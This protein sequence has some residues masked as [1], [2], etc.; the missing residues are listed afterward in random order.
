MDH[1]VTIK[2]DHLSGLEYLQQLI[3]GEL[4]LP[5]MCAT[6]PMTFEE[7]EL[8]FVRMTATAGVPHMNTI[9]GIHG[10]FAATVIDSVTGCA[11]H[12]LMEPG[13]GYTT[14][15][16]ELKMLRPPPLDEQMLVEG[17]VVN[18][19]RRLAVA[20]VDFE[21]FSSVFSCPSFSWA[22]SSCRCKPA[23]CCSA[24]FSRSRTPSPSC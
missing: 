6:I 19:S 15:S 1:Q 24:S 3:S 23:L 22:S 5:P 2:P 13:E 14:I 16:L 9:G 18:I 20:D 7:V 10:G 4:P 11:V 21:L 8:G 12:S 17:R